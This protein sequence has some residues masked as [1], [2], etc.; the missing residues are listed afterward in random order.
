MLLIECIMFNIMI[1]FFFF[2][3]KTAY[4]M[5]I[6]DWS[7]DVC[8]SDL[9][10]TIPGTIRLEAR[11]G[12]ALLASNVTVDLETRR[13]EGSGGVAGAVPAGTFSADRLQ[14]ALSARTITLDGNARLSLTPGQLRL[15]GQ[16]RTQRRPIPLPPQTR[17]R[18]LAS[19]C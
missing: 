12:Y 16:P 6:S 15:P 13:L 2:K 4:D 9:R 17:S 8:S 5:R 10:V 1:F 14:A 3:Q 18:L 19:R 11:D 7:S